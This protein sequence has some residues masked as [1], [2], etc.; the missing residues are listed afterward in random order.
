MA[1]KKIHQ[2]YRVLGITNVNPDSACDYR[3][4]AEGPLGSK[5]SCKTMSYELSGLAEKIVDNHM[6]YLESHETIRKDTESSFLDYLNLNVTYK[7]PYDVSII[8]GNTYE[9]SEISLAEKREFSERLN[10]RNCGHWDSDF[11]A[12]E[13]V[14]K[15]L[16]H[17]K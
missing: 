7:T 1:D 8:G 5:K 11:D 4:I 6:R 12:L 10:T 16:P 13:D 9:V 2:D 14:I 3:Y 15:H 17:L